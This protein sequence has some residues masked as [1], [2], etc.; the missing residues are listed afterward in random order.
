MNWALNIRNHS[1]N[2][3]RQSPTFRLWGSDNRLIN[4]RPKALVYVQPI[5]G[6]TKIWRPVKPKMIS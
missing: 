4:G 3:S 2:F 6:P 1:V 5:G